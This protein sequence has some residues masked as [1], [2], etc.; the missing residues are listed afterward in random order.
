LYLNKPVLGIW[1]LETWIS[2]YL[3]SNEGT[4]LV[5]IEKR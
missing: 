2:K 1:C 5:T 3:I 4:A